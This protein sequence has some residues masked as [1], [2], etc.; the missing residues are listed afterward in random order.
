[1]NKKVLVIGG[2]GFLGSSIAKK[3]S[4]TDGFEVTIGD[5]V[6]VDISNVRFCQLNVLDYFQLVPLIEDS[7]YVIN[8]TGQVTNPINTCLKINSDGIMNIVKAVKEHN[9]KLF[10]F[11]SVSVYG[12]SDYVN[13]ASDLNPESPYAMCKAFAEI[14]IINGL[15]PDSYCILRI[16]N[17]F[18][19]SQRKGIFA[20]LLKESK[21]SK[22]LTF[23]NDG[24]LARYYLHILDCT[25][26]LILA[27][28]KDLNQVYNI[29]GSNLISIISILDLIKTLKKIEFETNF[30]SDKPIENIRDFDANRFI[31]E[32]DF[33]PTVKIVDFI[34]K[35]F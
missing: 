17:L 20:Y 13:E 2:A 30:S 33:T 11:S 27:I 10:H 19:E 18:G 26:A 5:T 31:S 21:G 32:T 15:S 12:T 3:L 9:K 35:T 25:D 34:N 6:S 14:S 22:T 28:Q 29:P 4:Q 8:C 7:D 16:P 23:N 24:T 1:M